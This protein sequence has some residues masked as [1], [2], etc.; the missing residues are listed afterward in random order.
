[1]LKINTKKINNLFFQPLYETGIRF[2]KSLMHAAALEDGNTQLNVKG[3]A[4]CWLGSQ[5]YIASLQHA[6]FCDDVF[7]SGQRSYVLLTARSNVLWSVS[8][9]VERNIFCQQPRRKP[10]DL[11]TTQSKVL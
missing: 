6:S 2:L 3:E 7:L 8:I 4:S 1:M 5:K 11:S 9:L 10:C